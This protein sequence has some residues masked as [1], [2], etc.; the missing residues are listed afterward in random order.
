VGIGAAFVQD[1]NGNFADTPGKL[2]FD[3][4]S[5]AAVRS[6]VFYP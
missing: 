6:A 3:T 5:A 4:A 1:L 2:K